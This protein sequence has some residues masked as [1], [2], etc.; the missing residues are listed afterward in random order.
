MTEI[1]P[2]DETSHDAHAVHKKALLEAMNM[3]RQEREASAA[4]FRK[5]RRHALRRSRES[6]VGKLESGSR[7][8][9]IAAAS[10]KFGDWSRDDLDLVISSNRL[11]ILCDTVLGAPMYRD[12]WRVLACDL[13]PS[14]R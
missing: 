14:V 11:A 10:P 12:G 9:C 4:A 6:S 13:Q 2:M 5:S 1:D 8:F 7:E 3:W